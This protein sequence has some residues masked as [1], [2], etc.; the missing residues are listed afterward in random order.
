MSA[1]AIDAPEFIL[2]EPEF[3]PWLDDFGQ[4]LL[5]VDPED[6]LLGLDLVDLD[7][8]EPSCKGLTWAF[9]TGLFHIHNRTGRLV[10]VWTLD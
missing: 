8:G 1:T 6:A 4:P 5:E 10:S 7:E 3:D 2:Y 9:G